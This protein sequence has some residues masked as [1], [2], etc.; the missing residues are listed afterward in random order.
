MTGGNCT[1]TLTI[2]GSSS[3]APEGSTNKSWILSDD[4]TGVHDGAWH[5]PHTA[6]DGFD[7]CAFHLPSEELPDH[8]DI[9]E[10]FLTAVETANDRDNRFR[11][12][13]GRQFIGATFA[14]FDLE[15][16]KVGG[17]DAGEIDLRYATF[18]RVNCYRTRF[19]QDIRLSMAVF[20]APDTAHAPGREMDKH[21]NVNAV[22]FR[23]AEFTRRADFR[24]ATFEDAA[25][26]EG[27]L[28]KQW[29]GFR[30]ATFEDTADFHSV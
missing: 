24:G 18:E 3:S 15:G 29:T 10:Q 20:R 28:F 1:Y 6:V 17:G 11:R 21:E 7:K 30:D 19:D 14:E 25:G 2:P 13:R 16:A 26:F 23:G 9:T 5:C 22:G 27:A 12:R 8:I 4:D